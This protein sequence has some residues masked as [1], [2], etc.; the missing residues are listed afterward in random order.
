MATEP[1]DIATEFPDGVNLTDF[2]RDY[3]DELTTTASMNREQAQKL[4]GGNTV[5]NG[6]TK[7]RTPQLYIAG[8]LNVEFGDEPIDPNIRTAIDNTIAAQTGSD[9]AGPVLADMLPGDAPGQQAYVYDGVRQNPAIG[10]GSWIYWDG[11][12]SW[13]YIRDDTVA[14]TPAPVRA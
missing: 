14:V 7:P 2:Q 1:H 11:E 9:F 4:A 3:V 8:T 6:E 12:E 5:T 13:R 10:S